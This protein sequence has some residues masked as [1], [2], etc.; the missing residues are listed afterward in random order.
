MSYLDKN[1]T[2]AGCSRLFAFSAGEQALC[3]ELGYDQPGRCPA[4][5]RSREDAR[6]RGPEDFRPVPLRVVQPVAA[7]ASG[8][9]LLPP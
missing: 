9:A 2:C 7:L 6:R 8:A 4:C 5:R 3:G 1:L